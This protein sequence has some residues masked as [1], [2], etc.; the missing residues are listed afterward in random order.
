MKKVNIGVVG[1]GNISAIYFQ[2]LTALFPNTAVYACADLREEAA[3][4]A[5]KK[6]NIPHIMT[7]DEMLACDE[8]TIILN[9]TTPQTHYSICKKALE[10]GKHVYV[11]K[12]LS[13]TFEEGAE[14]TALAKKNKLFLGG[15]PD[16]FM[17]AGIQT[18]RKLIDDGFIG[19]PIGATAFMM[20]H[21]HESW[22]PSPAFYYQKGGGPLFDMGP[23]YITALINLLGGV[24][25]VSGMTAKSFAQ[26][27]ITSRPKFGEI[28]DVE[29]DTHVNAL[30]R[31]ESGAV[32]NLIT[33]FDIWAS[34]L[35]RIE[36]YGTKG[37]L[38]VPDPNAF[39]GPVLLATQNSR[40][41]K[42]IPFT[43]AYSGNS[44]GIGLADMAKCIETGERPKADAD[45]ICHVLEI[46]TAV[47]KSN[48]AGK[49]YLMQTS[50]QPAKPMETDIV[51]GMI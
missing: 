49:S 3:A 31:F 8:I 34:T 51:E 38:L 4:E 40:E 5:A 37:T 13:L 16:T 21:G 44:R 36:V 1:C 7:L 35:P 43:H 9:I 41:F 42:E 39:G 45:Q 33:S 24:K 12:P 20:C 28:I 10:A 18:S 46:M 22:H 32:G 11:E 14:L 2:N 23:Y 15:A 19:E 26:R 6:W 47:Q 30:M 25:E 27:V 17:G 48:D 29:V 50:Y